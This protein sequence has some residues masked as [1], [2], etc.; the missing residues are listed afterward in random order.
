ML[1]DE[2]DML[3]NPSVS[4]MVVNHLLIKLKNCSF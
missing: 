3:L 4:D 1:K 2:A